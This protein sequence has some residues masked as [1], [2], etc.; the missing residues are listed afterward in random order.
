[1]R[2]LLPYMRESTRFRGTNF[3]FIS[4]DTKLKRF[5][6]GG[7]NDHTFDNNYNNRP[8]HPDIGFG[9]RNPARQDRPLKREPLTIDQVGPGNFRF[10]HPQFSQSWK[11]YNS[12]KSS[13]VLPHLQV[14]WPLVCSAPIWSASARIEH[15]RAAWQPAHT[16][17]T[18]N[19]GG[20]N[21]KDADFTILA[22]RWPCLC[23]AHSSASPHRPLP[24]EILNRS[25]SLHTHS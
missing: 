16:L 14:F 7:P 22:C 25:G 5:K 20:K 10:I 9:S 18:F 3:A 17:S 12:F 15:R 23:A 1:M 13:L 8:G 6:H 24:H 21:G 4:S 11:R 19:F 2:L